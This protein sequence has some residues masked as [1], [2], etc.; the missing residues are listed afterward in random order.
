MAGEDLAHG[1]Y[2]GVGA[3]GA[4]NA[5]GALRDLAH[6]RFNL[7]LN[8]AFVQL[9]LPSGEAGAVVAQDCFEYSFHPVIVAKG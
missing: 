8:G 7:A 3:A 2:A 6:G 4:L 1:V 9:A 5:D